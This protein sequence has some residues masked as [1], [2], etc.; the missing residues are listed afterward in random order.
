MWGVIFKELRDNRESLMEM[1]WPFQNL[2][3]CYGRFFL[4]FSF[5]NSTTHS[6]LFTYLYRMYRLLQT[7]VSK[8]ATYQAPNESQCVCVFAF[9]LSSAHVNSSGT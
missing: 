3:D 4:F 6:E 1:H 8:S 5:E 9:M 2:I 7:N